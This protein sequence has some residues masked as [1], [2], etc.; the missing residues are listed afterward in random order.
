MAISSPRQGTVSDLDPADASTDR[1]AE[2]RSAQEG[3]RIERHSL[4]RSGSASA[5]KQLIAEEAYRRAERRG[6]APG[7]DWQDWFDAERE[8]DALLDPDL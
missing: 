8:V 1:T 4:N 6:F 3:N 7:D 5:R 2:P